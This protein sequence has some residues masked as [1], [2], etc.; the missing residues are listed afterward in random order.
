MSLFGAVLC[1]VAMFVLSWA[2]SLVTFLVLGVMFLFI[3]HNKAR[4]CLVLSRVPTDMNTRDRCAVFSFYTDISD[5]NWG[6][7]ADANRYRKALNSLLKITRSVEHVK[8]Y[9]PQ[10][11]VLTGNPAAR[12]S[13]VDFAYCITKG[14]NL[15]LCGHVIPVR[16]HG[17]EQS[18]CPRFSTTRRSQ[19]RHASGS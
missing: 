6:T 15:M 16:G 2:T 13:L 11:L 19:R 17:S 5:V 14:Q 8:N 3:K 10:L 1:V 9:R 18:S 4:K 12:Q 7:S